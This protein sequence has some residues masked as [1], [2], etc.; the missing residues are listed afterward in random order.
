MK[1][2]SFVFLFGIENKTV[3]SIKLQEYNFT[4][5]S[6]STEHLQNTAHTP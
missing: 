2:F 5:S 4:F 3:Q 6:I 1:G